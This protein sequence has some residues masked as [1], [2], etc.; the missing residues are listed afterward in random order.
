[1]PGISAEFV[2]QGGTIFVNGDV[3]IGDNDLPGKVALISD[4]NGVM[5]QLVVDGTWL[6][7]DAGEL[8]IEL[9]VGRPAPLQLY[10]NVPSANGVLTLVLDEGYVPQDGD[11]IPL[12]L[13][14]FIDETTSQF[15]IVIIDSPLPEGLY[16]KL[17]YIG[18]DGLRGGGLLTAEVELL[19]NLFD[20][21]NPNSETIIGT[22]T[23]VVIADLGSVARTAD[24]FDDIVITTTDLVH[25]FLSDGNGGFASQVTYSDPSFTSLSAIDAGD[26][27][28]DGTI[29]LV[30][31]NASTDEFIPM[32]NES[33]DIT[34][35]I[36]GDSVSTG[37]N[38]TDI[39][40]MNTDADSDADVIVACYGHT[41][42]DGEI[43]F[44]ESV[45]AVAGLFIATGSL[46][47]PGNPGKISPG[48]VNTDKDFPIIVS[49]GTANMLR[50]AKR[51]SGARGGNWEYVSSTNVSTGPSYVVSGDLDNDT[52]EDIVVSCPESD[53]ICIVRGNLDGSMA[54]PLQLYVGKDPMSIELL[55][56]DNDGDLDIAVIAT[57]DVTDN[58]AVMMY[59][60]DTT[61]NGGNFM[62]AEDSTFD[63][64]LNPVLVAK[65]DI[66]GDGHDDLIS[67]NQIILLQNVLL[68]L[69]K[70]DK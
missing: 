14:E 11:I 28:G 30:M 54:T 35:L 49:F 39:L 37:P 61:L 2:V 43:D 70:M 65:G 3:L 4:D 38:P 55:D 57:D 36:I 56:F 8:F 48:D 46:L 50:K 32:F 64:G 10:N 15:S 21:G 40:A 17:N 69:M 63:D 33:Q 59:R 7:H 68:T 42:E 12:M 60:N 47:S 53:V 41:L 26:L 58:R 29:D 44:Y 13:S 45:P 51:V 5:G 62:F 20:Y 34:Q 19:S 31:T 18:E 22:A 52:I 23:D 27:D 66:D 24:G 6:Q 25:V 67:G 9:N 1:V 16:I